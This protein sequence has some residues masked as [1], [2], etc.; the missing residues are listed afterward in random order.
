[1]G[2]AWLRRRSGFLRTIEKVGYQKD[3]DYDR[4][5]KEHSLL[6]SWLLLGIVV[7]GQIYLPLSR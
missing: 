2:S 6:D 7:F 5:E 3:D 1:L 4:P